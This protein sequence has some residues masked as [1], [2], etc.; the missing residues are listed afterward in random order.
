ML[1]LEQMEEKV[2]FLIMVVVG[3]LLEDLEEMEHVLAGNVLSG[4]FVEYTKK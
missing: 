4:T 1:I 2:W 3:E